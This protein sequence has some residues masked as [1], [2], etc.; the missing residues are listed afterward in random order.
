MPIV[1]EDVSGYILAGGQSSRMGSD[2][3]L[4]QFAGRP[5]IQHALDLLSQAGLSASIAGVRSDLRSFAPVVADL[6]PDSGPL[7]GIHAALLASQS[8][9]SLFL[10]VDLPLM[11]PSL[12]AILV[13][14][15]QLTAEPVVALRLNGRL[16]P[17]PVILHRNALPVIADR[18]RAGQSGCHAAWQAIPSQLGARLHAPAVEDLV[19]SGQVSHPAGYPPSWWFQS[20]NTLADLAWLNQLP[21]AHP[22]FVSP[23]Q[24]PAET[25]GSRNLLL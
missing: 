20:A 10:P 21:S 23:S 16:E 24:I 12:L 25:P 22:P 8:E 1:N 5:L 9:W 18:L 19:Q 7:A 6:A 14:R 15:A 13:H 4:V 17:F 3:A 11:P 2:K